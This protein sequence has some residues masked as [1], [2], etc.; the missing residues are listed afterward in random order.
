MS[1]LDD[2][3]FIYFYV[4]AA[5]GVAVGALPQDFKD[6]HV[7]GDQPTI[8]FEAAEIQVHVGLA[9]KNGKAARRRHRADSAVDARTSGN[10]QRVADEDGLG[11]H[12]DEGVT[13]TRSGGADGADNVQ[14]HFGTGS[15]FAWVWERLGIGDRCGGEKQRTSQNCGQQRF[16]EFPPAHTMSVGR[17]RVVGR[18]RLCRK[19]SAGAADPAFA[20]ANAGRM[21]RN[22]IRV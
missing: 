21:G 19:V 22:S 12:G 7:H 18:F 8:D 13:V 9:T 16:H 10:Q 15:N 20:E 11:K 3:A 6:A 1:L 2:L 5:R 17:P 14:A 4:V